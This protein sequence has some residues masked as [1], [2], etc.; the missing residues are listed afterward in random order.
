MTETEAR[1]RLHERINVAGFAGVILGV[2]V[3]FG[4]RDVPEASAVFP[5]L[6]GTLMIVLG[7][8]ELFRSLVFGLNKAEESELAIKKAERKD[9]SRPIFPAIFLVTSTLS[10]VVIISIIGFF[11]S[12]IMY[13]L[14]LLIGMQVRRLSYLIFIPLVTVGLIYFLFSVQLQVPLPSGILT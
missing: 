6:I 11:S 10:Y 12:T 13:I 4:V 7:V 2:L 5:S 8:V 1:F 3:L 14:L 9:K